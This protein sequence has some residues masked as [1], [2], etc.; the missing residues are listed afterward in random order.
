[1][2]FRLTGKES[3]GG[4]MAEK[5]PKKWLKNGIL[6]AFFLFSAN[7]LRIPQRGKNPFSGHFFAE[8]GPKARK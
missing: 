1:M 2:D 6:G 7:F 4:E 3:G 8:I 5:S